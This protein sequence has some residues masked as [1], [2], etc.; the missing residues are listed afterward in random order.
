MDAM[1]VMQ[2]LRRRRSKI[3]SPRLIA[4]FG[5]LCPAL[6]CPPGDAMGSGALSGNPVAIQDGVLSADIRGVTVTEVIKRLED[7]CATRFY[8]DE[9]ILGE[10]LYVQFSKL[11]LQESIMKI[12]SG[13][14]YILYF[15][16]DG[17]LDEV[18]LLGKK[19]TLP[20]QRSLAFSKKPTANQ[21]SQGWKPGVG[22]ERRL[23]RKLP[24][25]PHNKVVE[26]PKDP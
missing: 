18:V 13:M 7:E 16:P 20:A 21:V 14:N 25:I 26:T 15:L 10:E 11:P 17:T 24:K 1:D 23:I 8:V 9:S 5:L 12:F 2:G 3:V 6:F 19:G 22:S 4:L